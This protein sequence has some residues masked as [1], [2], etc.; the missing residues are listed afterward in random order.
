MAGTAQPCH[1]VMSKV[2][3]ALCDDHGT[4][5]CRKGKT[6]W[7]PSQITGSLLPGF[8]HKAHVCISH[9]IG[10]TKTEFPVNCN[11]ACYVM[12]MFGLTFLKVPGFAQRSE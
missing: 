10:N 12:C 8:Y 3:S 4:E 5:D 9:S 1:L 2:S 6:G 11:K 7:R